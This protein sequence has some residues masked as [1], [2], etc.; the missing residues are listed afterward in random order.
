MSKEDVLSAIQMLSQSG[1][2]LKKKAI[3]KN[4]P[5]LMRSA[6]HYYPDWDSAVKNSTFEM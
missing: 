1:A 2:E 3:K 6:L 5:E 4:N